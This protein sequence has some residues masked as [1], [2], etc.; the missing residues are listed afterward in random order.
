MSASSEKSLCTSEGKD[1]QERSS[2]TRANENE[3]A[4]KDERRNL[5]CDLVKKIY[6]SDFRNWPILSLLKPEFM[7]QIRMVMV[8]G[9]CGNRALI[10]TKDKNVYTLDYNKDDYLKNGDTHI[11][12]YPK[13]IEELCGRNIKT[14]ACNSYFVLAL[15]EEGEVYSWRFKKKRKL[16]DESHAVVTSTPTRVACL[17]EER[18]VDIACGSDHSL[19]LTSD[20]KVYAWG[21]NKYG[22]IGNGAGGHADNLPRQVKHE[23]EGKKIVHIACGSMFNMVVSDKGKL[24]GWGSNQRGQISIN[25]ATSSLTTS[26]TVSS[27]TAPSIT[28]FSSITPISTAFSFSTP[29]STPPIS[30][31]PSFTAF[32]SSTPIFTASCST[33]PIFTASSLTSSFST[34]KP[35][36]ITIPAQYDSKTTSNN[37]ESQK[38]YPRKITVVSDK[39]IAQLGSKTTSN[40]VGPQKYCAYP[41]KIIAVSNKAIAQ[42]GSKTTSN[43][44]QLQKLYAYPRKITAMSGKVIVKVACGSEHTLALTDEGKVYTWGKNDN[45]QLGVND[46]LKSST[47][48]MVNLPEMEKVLDIAAYGNLSVAVGSNKTVYVWGDCFGEII[49]T[50]FPTGLSRIHDA[51][52]YNTTSV[53]HRPLTVSTNSD[54]EKVL[55]IFEFLGALFDDPT[56]SDFTVQVEGRPIRVHRTI[57]KIR[58]Q[59]FKNKFEHDWTENG[60]SIPDSPAIYIVSDKFSYVVYKAFLKYLYT[61]IVDLSLEKVLELMKLADEY[62]ETNLKRECDQLIKQAI[63]ASNVVFFYSKAIECNAKELEEFCFQYALC[64]MTDV[65]LSEEYIKLDTSIKDNFM[66]RAAQNSIFKT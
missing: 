26:F 15:T 63:T 40:N 42:L 28:A 62:C 60:E 1:A 50:P 43:T 39:A 46:K 8:Y 22:Q 35:I 5:P 7:M 47:L 10:V 54:V 65:V 19:A 37:V 41:R 34:C 38:Y 44:V 29:I 66:R 45:G 14:F 2:E 56:T 55:N 48:V 12:L 30:T 31:A 11:G 18:I 6:P 52:A 16:D 32:S 64:H 58:C 27:C 57:L 4:Q 51:F 36:S 9:N 53:M 24:Y 17:S 21:E 33:T 13:K 61:G 20:G 23:L 25:D 59:H 3:E 49:T